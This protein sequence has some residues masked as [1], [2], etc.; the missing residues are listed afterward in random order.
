MTVPPDAWAAE[1]A[2]KKGDTQKSVQPRDNQ[3]RIFLTDTL[4]VG[5]TER[6]HN[7]LQCLLCGLSYFAMILNAAFLHL[8]LQRIHC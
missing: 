1:C 7:R 8:I 4:Q 6:P 2:L 3:K 5:P